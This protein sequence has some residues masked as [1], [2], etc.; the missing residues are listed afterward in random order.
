MLISPFTNTPVDA[1][2]SGRRKRAHVTQD[3]P[4]LFIYQHDSAKST[5]SVLVSRKITSAQ[6]ALEVAPPVP[7]T[8]VEGEPVCCLG[9]NGGSRAPSLAKRG[10]EEGRSRGKQFTKSVRNRDRNWR[11]CKTC[12]DAKIKVRTCTAAQG[13]LSISL[14]ILSL[15]S[16]SS[17]HPG[18]APNAIVSEW[19]SARRMNLLRQGRSRR[20]SLPRCRT[21]IKAHVLMLPL[22]LQSSASKY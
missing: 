17:Y 4:S 1:G 19:T 11:P 2:G 16:V 6:D 14:T 18:Y 3:H 13:E 21:D 12:S 5:L 7:Y 9:G 15:H 10:E 22:Q 8:D 20:L